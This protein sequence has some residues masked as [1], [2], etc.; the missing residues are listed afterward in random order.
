MNKSRLRALLI[1]SVVAKCNAP[2]QMWNLS[3]F[4]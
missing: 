2:K 3:K 1:Y 4:I